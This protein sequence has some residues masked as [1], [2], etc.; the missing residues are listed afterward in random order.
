LQ[1]RTRLLRRYAKPKDINKEPSKAGEIDLL[2]A[3]QF[4][5]QL[6][7][8]HSSVKLLLQPRFEGRPSIHERNKLDT[9][10]LGWLRG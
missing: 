9:H 3:A 7:L 5:L 4:Q 8:N 6:V 2:S 1:L 10:Y